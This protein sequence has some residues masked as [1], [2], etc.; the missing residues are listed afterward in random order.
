MCSAGLR[1]RTLQLAD[2]WA[3]HPTPF[4]LGRDG[5]ER[6]IDDSGAP[7]RGPDEHLVGVMLA[8]RDAS[9]RR[10]AEASTIPAV[11]QGFEGQV[12]RPLS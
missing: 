10:R 7:I 1:R 9:D 5:T 11:V 4:L 3:A 12:P 2:S 6:P 8:F